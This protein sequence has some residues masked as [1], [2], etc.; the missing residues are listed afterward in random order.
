M[1]FATNF[2]F[3][4]LIL[5]IVVNNV[6][7][8]KILGIFPMSSRSHYILGS[9]LLKG[10]A[11]HGHEVTM[12]SPFEEKNPPKNSVFKNVVLTGFVEDHDRKYLTAKLLLPFSN[13]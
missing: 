6:Q 10:L 8:A 7:S 5:A 9:S 3:L 4:V 2:A 13:R 1:G 12:I 11:E